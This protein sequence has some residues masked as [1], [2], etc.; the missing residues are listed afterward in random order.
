MTSVTLPATGVLAEFRKQQSKKTANYKGD[1]L[2][3]TLRNRDKR[4]RDKSHQ[5][6]TYQGDIIVSG[7]RKG[8]HPSA[9][10]NGGRIK[11]SY[12][13]KEK[14]RKRM[15]KKFKRKGDVER[16]DSDKKEDGS[17]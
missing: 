7:R 10:Y 11:N 2:V 1:L 3:K 6:A 5:A 9:V 17:A 15:L 8:Q 13:A 16:P 14:Y 4:M 12:T